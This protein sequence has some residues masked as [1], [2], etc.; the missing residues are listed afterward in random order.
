MFHRDSL[1][2]HRDTIL[3]ML[4]IATIFLGL[5]SMVTPG[6]AASLRSPQVS[7]GSGSLQSYLNSVSEA[8]NVTTDQQDVQTWTTTISGNTT[9]TLMLELA[10]FAGNN[11]YGLYNTGDPSATPTLFQV[12]PGGAAPGWFATAHFGAGGALIVSLFDENAIYQG[13]TS[14]AGI[15]KYAFGFYI[16]GPGGTFY[17]QD[18][19]NGGTANVLTFAGTGQNFG[20]WW[21]CFDDQAYNAG[22]HDFDD[23]VIF[24]ES[25]NPQPVPTR[26]TTWG[27]IKSRYR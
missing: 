3:G 6:N 4:F 5:A 27:N 17:S 23:G 22:D 8:I 12:F 13:Q 19:R 11:S 1:R 25:V 2:H 26:P 14:Y 24:V 20:N 7:I 21:Q 10:G 16:Q 15:N 18:S 9:L